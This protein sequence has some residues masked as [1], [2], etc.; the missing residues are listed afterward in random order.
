MRTPVQ[1]QPAMVGNLS[2]ITVPGSSKG[3]ISKTLAQFHLAD[4]IKQDVGGQ[5]TNEVWPSLGGNSVW[6]EGKA[7]G[8][9]APGAAA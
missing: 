5:E 3:L 6:T 7:V 8:Q 9:I 2:L 1:V 4:S